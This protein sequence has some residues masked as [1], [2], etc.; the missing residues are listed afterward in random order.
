MS[1]KSLINKI[2]KRYYFIGLLA[3]GILY[4]MVFS[5]TFHEFKGNL[6]EKENPELLINQKHTIIVNNPSPFLY[7]NDNAILTPINYLVFVEV[8]K[9]QKSNLV[10]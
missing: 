3:A 1:L 5:N 4:F 9:S 10:N 2:K 6:T 7:E 8:I